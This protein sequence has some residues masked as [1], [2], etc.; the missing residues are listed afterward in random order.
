MNFIESPEK[1]SDGSSSKDTRTF[2]YWNEGNMLLHKNGIIIIEEYSYIIYP[3]N[4]KDS[5][6]MITTSLDNAYNYLRDGNL[7]EKK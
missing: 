4:R 2:F 1:R 6:K 3:N 7:E 5:K